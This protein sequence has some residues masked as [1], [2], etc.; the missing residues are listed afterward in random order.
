[1]L[2]R[3]LAMIEHRNIPYRDDV[4]KHTDF[5]RYL[6]RHTCRAFPPIALFPD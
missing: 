5:Q 2:N 6:A 4:E 3:G 1:V